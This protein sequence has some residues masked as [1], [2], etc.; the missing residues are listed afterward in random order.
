VGYAVRAIEA[1]LAGGKRMSRLDLYR[2]TG[3]APTV[4]KEAFEHMVATGQLVADKG[5]YLLVEVAT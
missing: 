3:L 4:F 5:D 1:V 2:A